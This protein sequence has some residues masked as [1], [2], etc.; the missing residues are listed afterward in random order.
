MNQKLIG[1]FFIILIVII[2]V[3]FLKPKLNEEDNIKKEIEKANFC[4]T[5][6]DCGQVNSQCPFGCY[7]F[8]NKNEVDRIN[9]LLNSYQATCIYNCVPLI[10][11]DCIT[12]KC[13]AKF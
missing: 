6:D 4:T 9:D 3:Y 12:N 7:V 8:V 11:Y 2:G 1:I 10:D 13:E 5:K